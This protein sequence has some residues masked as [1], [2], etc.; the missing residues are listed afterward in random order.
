MRTNPLSRMGDAYLEL[1]KKPAKDGG[2]SI[3]LM[4]LLLVGG[5]FA[6]RGALTDLVFDDCYS[7]QVL[8][9]I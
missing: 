1:A 5:G 6:K 9:S 8:T 3:G 7:F 2:E 4:E